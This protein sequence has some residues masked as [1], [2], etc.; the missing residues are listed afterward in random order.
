MLFLGAALL[1]LCFG[2]EA[3]PMVRA[4]E[5]VQIIPTALA[6][7]LGATAFWLAV[8]F[9]FGRIYCSSVCPIGTI[10][11]S[12]TFLRRKHRI[13]SRYRHRSRWNPLVLLLYV[14]ALLLGATALAWL[15]QPWQML[16]NAVALF[17]AYAH[18]RYVSE[19]IFLFGNATLGCIV[20][21]ASVVAIWVWALLQGRRFCTDICPIGTV[22]GSVADYALYHIEIDPDKCTGCMKCEYICK[23]QCIKV[24]SRYTDNARC[25]RCFDCLKVC[26]DDA[27][28]LQ[29]N[30]NRRMNPLFQRRRLPN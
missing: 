21:A 11:D 8:T 12:A 18:T 4:S 7:T 23:A 27:I 9:V 5:R 25:V 10:Q 3:N 24:I 2:P 22:L 30:R 28:H 13:S 16:A 14:V 17:P 26:P 15:L 20:A 19:G 29:R 1:F 6:V